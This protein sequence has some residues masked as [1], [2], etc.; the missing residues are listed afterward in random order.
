MTFI[1]NMLQSL[2]YGL[3]MGLTGW[4]PISSAAH[5][6]LMKSFLPLRVYNDYLSN[7]AFWDLY[8][9][10]LQLGAVLAVLLLF[11]SRLNPFQKGLRQK[12]RRRIERLWLLVMISCLPA[13]ILAILMDEAISTVLTSG[14][15]LAV[16]LILFGAF[17]IWA[18]MKDHDVRVENTAQITPAD[19]LKISLFRFMSLLPGIGYSGS[20]IMG[21]ELIGFNRETAVEYSLYVMIPTAFG[22]IVFRLIRFFLAGIAFSAEGLAVSLIGMLVSFI[23]SLFTIR[24]LMRHV[25]RQDFRIFG[26]YR[27]ILGV[28]FVIFTLFGV[29]S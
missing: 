16:S 18:E 22:S 4:L 13:G 6:T 3:V 23:V 19:A 26:V 24:F 7:Q 12:R 28:L 25:R 20:T 21:G 17:M 9:S 10:L 29:F 1:L 14:W 5:L 2:L 27:I 11:F 8:R 15:V